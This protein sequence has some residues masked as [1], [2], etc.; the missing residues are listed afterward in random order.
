[1]MEMV[2]GNTIELK[3]LPS[4]VCILPSAFILSPVCSPQSAFYTDR[5]YQLV[6]PEQQQIFDSMN[7]RWFRCSL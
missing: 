6:I 7:L 3:S 5:L 2:N 1:M 4:A